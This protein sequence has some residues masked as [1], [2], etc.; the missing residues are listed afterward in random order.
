MVLIGVFSFPCREAAAPAGAAPSTEHRAPQWHRRMQPSRQQRGV[1]V[2]YKRARRRVH[3]CT[4]V[5][6]VPMAEFGLDRS[7][8]PLNLGDASGAGEEEAA[9]VNGECALASGSPRTAGGQAGVETSSTSVCP[10]GTSEMPRR[11]S[12]IKVCVGVCVGV[13]CA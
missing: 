8:S 7:L 4:G 11:S 9:V 2:E 3:V 1:G 13:V 12:I 10:D 6:R 5:H